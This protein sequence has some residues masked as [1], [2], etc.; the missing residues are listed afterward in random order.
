MPA[1]FSRLK[2]WT[3]EVL[4]YAALN[5][6]FD[7]ILNNLIPSGIGG[8]SNN[9][10]QMRMTTD[11]FPGDNPSFATSLAGEI[12]RLRY[13]IQAILGTDADYWYENPTVTLSQITD[14]ILEGGLPN[15][16]LEDGPMGSDGMIR[17]LRPDT[18]ANGTAKLDLTLAALVYYVNGT[19]YQQNSTVNVTGFSAAPA[20]NNTMLVNGV[21]FTAQQFTQYYGEH[22]TVIPVD[23]VGSEITAVAGTLQTF[24]LVNSS[25]QTEYFLGTYL[26]DPILGP[27]VR[28][29][30]RGNFFDYQLV[31]IPRRSFSDNNVLTLQKTAWL[32][33]GTNGAVTASYNTPT[34]SLAAPAG[35][36]IGDYWYDL[37]DT[38]WHVYGP[39]GW[40]L[41]NSVLV[42]MV[43]IDSSGNVVA[44][45]TADRYQNYQNTNEINIEVNPTSTTVIQQ[46]G[47]GGRISV[48][49]NILRYGFRNQTWGSS[50]VEGGG[51]LA[52]STTYY[53]YLEDDGTP[54]LST[55]APH[56]RRGDLGGFY[57][58]SW[59]WRSLGYVTT[60]AGSVFDPTNLVSFSTT[61][62]REFYKQAKGTAAGQILTTNAV[63]EEVWTTG[64]I[65][66]NT[67]GSA[68]G[69][70]QVGEILTVS[71][72]SGS[73]ISVPNNSATTVVT[74]NLPPGRYRVYG[75]V[76][77]L[78][79]AGAATFNL[80]AQSISLVNNASGAF[81]RSDPYNGQSFNS[82]AI[83]AWRKDAFETEV[84]FTVTTPV[85]L[86]SY[87]LTSAGNVTAFGDI[88]AQRIW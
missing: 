16:R 54:W 60:T 80:M 3:A 72:A 57:H 31:P 52:A 44:A 34:W 43:V 47:Y 11:P 2:V 50:N 79:T 24:R 62:D 84:N 25:A 88:F 8:Y 61:A 71:R 18:G 77:Y 1:N 87:I 45:R 5:A 63:G 7:N 70:G 38:N 28:M 75:L 21:Q 20:A 22:G 17:A 15:S 14:L 85:Y 74:L 49:G 39:S 46:V 6:E 27:V 42:G 59:A 9:L 67:N 82:G 40:S 32:F 36:S 12:E 35:P 53:V 68:P 19:R 29:A 10:A 26:I 69:T 41:A 78:T 33:I 13:Q 56:D 86:V 64:G 65:L 81:V 23:T 66:G 76:G 55:I 37:S 73:S 4:D 83:G 48:Y 51:G 30:R 58:P